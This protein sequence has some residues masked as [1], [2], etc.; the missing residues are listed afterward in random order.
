MLDYRAANLSAPERAL[1]D[2]AVRLTLRPH[3]MSQGDIDALR[4]H[5]FGDAQITIAVQVISYFNYIN[6]VADALGV[7]PEPWMAMRK[8]DWL[9]RKAHDWA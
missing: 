9:A 6:R 7:D 5:G 1:C 8:E 3:D 2:F 4:A